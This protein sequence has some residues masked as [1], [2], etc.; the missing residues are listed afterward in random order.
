MEHQVDVAIIGAGAVVRDAYIG[1]YTAIVDG[2]ASSYAIAIDPSGRLT[3]RAGDIDGRRSRQ[4]QQLAHR[5]VAIV[6][7]D[8]ASTF[9]P[10]ACTAANASRN[11][12]RARV[13][14]DSA[15]LGVHCKRP[16]MSSTLNS[17]RYFHSSARL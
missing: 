5:L 14:S 8:H 10:A 17:S 16:A 12:L 2:D 6:R 7:T 9:F 1:P 13:N 4:P 15:A 3:W 11:A